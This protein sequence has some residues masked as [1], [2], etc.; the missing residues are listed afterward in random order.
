MDTPKL[1]GYGRLLLLIVV[2]ILLLGFGLG[3]TIGLSSC[4]TSK[5]VASESVS[6]ASP[7]DTGQ[8]ARDQPY[9]AAN[10][11]NQVPTA[12]ADQP[13]G[14]GFLGLGKRSGKQKI[15]NST[16]INQYGTGNIAA[17]PTKTE[18][19]TQLGTGNKA[20]DNREAGAD[21]GAAGI[22][23]GNAPS[24]STKEVGPPW[25]VYGLLVLAGAT[26]G[27]ILRNH[28]SKWAWVPARWKL[29]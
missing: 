2:G 13:K 16:I 10:Y 18:A 29:A 25:W 5:N 4:A 14:I 8:Y 11:A 23:K 19:P 28:A 1:N 27:W 6:D 22:G 17:V 20:T 9:K 24:V 26:G 3:I 12:Q 15:K 7:E 21:G